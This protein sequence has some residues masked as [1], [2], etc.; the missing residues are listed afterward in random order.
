MGTCEQSDMFSATRQQR[1]HEMA[2]RP[3]PL[4]S[5]HMDDFEPLL[6]IA[7]QRRQ[8]IHPV[9]GVVLRIVLLSG[10]LLQIIIFFENIEKALFLRRVKITHCQSTPTEQSRS[11][12]SFF[13]SHYAK[14]GALSHAPLSLKTV[15]LIQTFWPVRLPKPPRG[16]PNPESSSSTEAVIRRGIS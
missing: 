11:C 6:R 10:V 7:G 8:R 12:R 1:G 14:R 3:L 9:Q 16:L 4:R 13:T 2:G 5:S 15:R